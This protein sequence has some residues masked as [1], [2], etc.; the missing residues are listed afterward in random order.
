VAPD[1]PAPDETRAPRLWLQWRPAARLLCL[2]LILAALRPAPALVIP[3]PPQTVQTR[4]DLL[5]V[6][7]RLTDEVEPWK[8]Q[9]S[10]Q[11]VREM[12]APW[13]VEFF[14][15]AYYAAADGSFA[16]S[17]PDLIISHAEAQGLTVV[18]RL[19]LTPDWARPPDTSLNYLD[20]DGYQAFAAYAAAFAER[21]RGRVAYII[22]GNEPNLSFEWGYRTTTPHDYV[23][24]LQVVYPAV[25]AANAEMGILAGALAPTLEPPGSPWGL[26]DLIYLEGM[27]EAGAAPYFDALAVH[28][29]GFTFPP[30]A[31]PGPQLLNFRRVELL[32]EIM[33]AHGDEDKP[34]LITEMGWNDHPRWTRAVRPAQR[35]QYT[36]DAFR[37]AEA[38]WPYV[39]LMAIWVFRFPA[40]ARSYMDYFTLVTPEFVAKP[41]YDE[42]RLFTGN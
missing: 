12:G 36:L 28:T 37:Y 24:L 19:G 2:A 22:V 42:L 38:H 5:G 3:G 26:N 11:M 41:L 27:Y 31:E 16:W 18:A 29:Y 10:L 40:P 34:M 23:E 15:W 32:R 33:V 7:T 9:R 39:K 30:E 6:H 35:I 21:Y 1:P 17:H 13:I 14:P 4:M 25:K 8:I 20:T